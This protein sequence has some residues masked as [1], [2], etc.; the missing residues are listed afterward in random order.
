MFWALIGTIN[1][2]WMCS[3]EYDLCG[4][5]QMSNDDFDWT[6]NRGPTDTPNTGPEQAYDGEW[7]MYS[8][9]SAP[10]VQK[11]RA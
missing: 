8:E 11:E 4:M 2:P 7:Y 1:L 9:S 6:R 10:R 3:F 5:T